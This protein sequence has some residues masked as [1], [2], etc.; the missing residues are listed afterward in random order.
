MSKPIDCCRLVDMAKANGWPVGVNEG[1]RLVQDGAAVGGSSDVEERE[2]E[3]QSQQALEG[4]YPNAS[5]ELRRYVDILANRGMEWGLLGPREGGRLWQRHVA[6]S[7][8][9]VDVIGS[10]LDVADVG[11]GAGLPGLPLAIVRPDLHVTLIE[12]LLRRS[13][14]LQLAVDELGLGDRVDVLRAR[15]EECKATFDVVVCRAVAPLEKLLK[16]TV[17]LFRDGQLVALKGESAEDEIRSASKKV[18]AL[19]LRAEVLELQAAPG[20][21][22]TRAIRVAAG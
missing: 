3:A 17:P 22:R 2:L 9:L 1:G 21:G 5:E 6:N 13:N 20:V 14:F 10:G 16:W 8:A 15:A 18:A 19:G 4:I 7:L 12:P 11:S